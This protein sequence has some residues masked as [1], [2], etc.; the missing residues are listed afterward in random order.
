MSKLRRLARGKPCLVRLPGCDGGGE[1]TVLAH[2]RL[3]GY[4]GVG[5]K[6][7]D[8][9]GAWSCFKCHQL[10]D[11]RAYLPNLTAAEIRLP[12]AVATVP[13]AGEER[14]QLRRARGRAA[15]GVEG[16]LR[17]PAGW[18][19]PAAADGGSG[20][21]RARQGGLENAMATFWNCEL[22]GVDGRWNVVRQERYSRELVGPIDAAALPPGTQIMLEDFDGQADARFETDGREWKMVEMKRWN[23]EGHIE[24]EGVQYLSDDRRRAKESR[25]G[26]QR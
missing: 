26:S 20:P 2:Y 7:P 3:A 25:G 18:G 6:P 10:V 4:S 1:T 14:L 9:M 21:C 22:V 17:I 11:K 15:G 19:V 12:Q 13:L 8:I 16:A 5:K 23:I 24:G